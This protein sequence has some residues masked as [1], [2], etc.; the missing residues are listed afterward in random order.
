M[1][2]NGLKSPNDLYLEAKNQNMSWYGSYIYIV[3]LPYNIT[4]LYIS[5]IG[6]FIEAKTHVIS[7]CTLFSDFSN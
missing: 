6:A 4:L 1:I 7:I 2:T 3:T 5:V